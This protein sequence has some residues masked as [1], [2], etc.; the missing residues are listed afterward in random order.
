MNTPIYCSLLF[1]LGLLNGLNV[2]F[3][4][5]NFITHNWPSKQG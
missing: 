3:F 1:S 4:L 2:Q 5:I